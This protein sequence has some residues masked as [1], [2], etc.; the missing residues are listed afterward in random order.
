M[1]DVCEVTPQKQGETR[2]NN[3]ENQEYSSRGRHGSIQGETRDNNTRRK[4]GKERKE[5]H[6]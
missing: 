3:M 1:K 5:G 6:R 4:E 2:G